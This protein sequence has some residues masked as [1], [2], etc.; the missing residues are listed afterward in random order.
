MINIEGPI[1]STAKSPI[2]AAKIVKPWNEVKAESPTSNNSGKD[3]MAE[4]N[5]LAKESKSNANPIASAGEILK[6]QE[7]V[8]NEMRRNIGSV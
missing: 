2:Y 5:K 4:M 3:F 7:I 1:G 6:P 8:K